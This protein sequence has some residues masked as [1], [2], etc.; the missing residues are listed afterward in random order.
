MTNAFSNNLGCPGQR[1]TWRWL[2][3]LALLAFFV[4]L[5]AQTARAQTQSPYATATTLAA[6]ARYEEALRVLQNWSPTEAASREQK[7]W[8]RA[9]ILRQ[10]GR[11][12]DALPLLEDLVARRPDIPRFRIALGETLSALGQTERAKLHLEESRLAAETEADRTRAAA[13]LGAITNKSDWS[14][15]LSFS[16]INS[17]NA[18]QRTSAQT[19]TLLGTNFVINPTARK[20]AAKGLQVQAGL[21]FA[22]RIGPRT[23]LR[24]GLSAEARYYSKAVP[25]DVKLRAETTLVFDV[26]PSLSIE[27][28]VTFSRR[29]IDEKP[30]SQGPGLAFAMTAFPT[31]RSRLD[32][33]AMLDRVIHDR[34]PGIDG[35]QGMGLL[36]YTYALSPQLHLNGLLRAER[37]DAALASASS[38]ALE[39]GIGATMMLTG[40]MRMGLTASY[41]GT[42]YD[43]AAPLFA[44]TRYDRQTRATLRASHSK[45]QINGFTPELEVQYTKRT[46]NIVIYSYDELSASVG[47]TRRF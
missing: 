16:A 31:Q 12:D 37:T 26:T 5:F 18:A 39:A 13:G 38:T 4:G 29:W 43:A 40:G 45:L 8:A 24:T 17:S 11:H 7:T 36:S 41:R 20:Q 9:V 6:A 35:H 21:T 2:W 34:S 22:P 1:L 28:G 3:I 46:S 47:L 10:L 33:I 23:R 25:T 42:A 14:G 44:K 19:I 27:G 30:Y 32:L 15:R